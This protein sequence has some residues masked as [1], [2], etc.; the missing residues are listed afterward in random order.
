[1]RDSTALSEKMLRKIPRFSVMSS[2][3]P[4]SKQGLSEVFWPAAGTPLLLLWREGGSGKSV[5]PAD[6]T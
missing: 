6:R 5:F 3:A 4:V 2:T 1:M